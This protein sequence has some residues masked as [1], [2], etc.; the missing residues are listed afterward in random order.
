MG[1]VVDVNGNQHIAD[2]I[3]ITD[4]PYQIE[5]NESPDGVDRIIYER[6]FNI[7]PTAI[8]RIT[9]RGKLITNEWALGDWNNRES[10]DY[11]PINDRN[12]DVQ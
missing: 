7:V 12:G 4:V 3:K 5:V 8:K 10:L 1:L 6:Y 2:F 11:M 9:V